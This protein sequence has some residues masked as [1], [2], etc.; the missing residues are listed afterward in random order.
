M[1]DATWNDQKEAKI[2]QAERAVSGSLDKL[3]AALESLTQKV[4]GS[5]QR[6]QHFMDMGHRQKQELLRLKDN[7]QNA[8]LPLLR[9]G[10]D[11]GQRFYS[12]ARANPRPLLYGAL[13]LAGALLLLSYARRSPAGKFVDESPERW[14]A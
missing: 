13:A 6:I 1:N 2:N 5:N 14:A 3:E 11:T 7:A 4:E 12:Q 10:R 9:Q 8:I